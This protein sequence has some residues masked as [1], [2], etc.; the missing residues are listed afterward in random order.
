VT[1]ENKAQSFMKGI[2][3]NDAVG[4]KGPEVL[5]KS[6]KKRVFRKEQS[7]FAQHQDKNRGSGLVL[8]PY[9]Y[10]LI[11]DNECTFHTLL[12]VVLRAKRDDINGLTYLRLHSHAGVCEW[13]ANVLACCSAEGIQSTNNIYVDGPYDCLSNSARALGDKQQPK[14]SL[15]TLCRVIISYSSLLSF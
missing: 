2:K 7:K 15:N 3:R 1:R 8:P 6:I 11:N 12:S 5:R 9:V 4:D 13:S 14:Y 10:I